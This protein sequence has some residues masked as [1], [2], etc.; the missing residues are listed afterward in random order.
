MIRY[1]K[2]SVR[3]A[4]T[5]LVWVLLFSAESMFVAAAVLLAHE[6]AH[7]AACRALGVPVFGISALPWGLTITTPLMYEPGRQIFIS[8]AGPLCNFVLIGICCLIRRFFSVSGEMFDFFV[9]ANL[10]DGVFNLLP[11]LPLDGGIILK[12]V[13]CHLHGLVNGVKRTIA[14]TAAVGGIVFILGMFVFIDTGSNFSFAVVGL[15][16]L[17][18]LRRENEL[19]LC[20]RK[21]I[22]TGE[23]ESAAKIRYVR[24]QDTCRAICLVGTV[25]CEYATVYL[26]EKDGR[27]IG[28]VTCGGM[29]AELCKNTAVTMGEC[30]AAKHGVRAAK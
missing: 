22:L 8:A 25:T 16:V 21:R 30:A 14:V 4:L 18:N 28:E 29:I 17:F 6:A 13:L 3:F 9:I 23:I 19:L 11:A 12:A 1:L 7:W 2:P 24:V 10:A 27:F 20:L 5:L 15:F 26:V